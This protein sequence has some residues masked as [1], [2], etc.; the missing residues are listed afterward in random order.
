MTHF[1]RMI[2]L[3]EQVFDSRNDPDQLDV[4][5]QVLERLARI[6]PS[7]VSEYD[8]GNGPA[9]W[10]LVL[11]TTMELM[12]QFIAKDISERELFE[13]TPFDVEYEAI[14]LCSAMVLEEYRRQGIAGRLT[15]EAVESIRRDN[16]VKALFIWAFSSEGEK[17]SEKIARLTSLPLHKR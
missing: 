17:G 5:Q 8:D 6:H 2:Q 10:V 11:P 14:Y 3:A 15:L 4:D 12:K 13:R 7:A 1:E 16:P 9:A